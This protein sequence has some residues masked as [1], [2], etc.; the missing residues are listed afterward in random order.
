MSQWD[1]LFSFNTFSHKVTLTHWCNF[2]SVILHVFTSDGKIVAF[3]LRRQTQLTARDR[4]LLCRK[5]N[6]NLFSSQC[7]VKHVYFI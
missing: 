6:E 3:S 1:I 5:A 4:R 7:R 2:S